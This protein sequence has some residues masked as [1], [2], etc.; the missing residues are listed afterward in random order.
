MNRD[1][2]LYSNMLDNIQKSDTRLK[3]EHSDLGP[4]TVSGS[5]RSSDN[6]TNPYD[7]SSGSG[8][9]NGIST[10]TSD[11]DN[12]DTGSDEASLGKKK[13]KLDVTFF[14]HSRPLQKRLK[15]E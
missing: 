12:S 15:E 5:D 11:I 7:G 14:H 10:G 3:S 6:C 8:S 4:N 13:H 9:Q 1:L 2:E